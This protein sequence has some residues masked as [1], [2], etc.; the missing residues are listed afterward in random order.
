MGPEDDWVLIVG[1]SACAVDG[2]RGVWWESLCRVVGFDKM[3]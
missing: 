2:V 3:G 1:L